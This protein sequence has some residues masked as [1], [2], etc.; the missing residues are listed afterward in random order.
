MAARR[1]EIADSTAQAEMNSLMAE[2]TG[3]DAG[4]V[5]GTEVRASVRRLGSTEGCNSVRF[6][7]RCIVGEGVAEE[8]LEVRELG[9][10]ESRKSIRS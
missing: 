5:T 3:E 2:I 10:L 1:W 4:T 6:V 8:G 9:L 7:M